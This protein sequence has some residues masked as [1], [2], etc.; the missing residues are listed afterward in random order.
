VIRAT[1]VLPLY[2]LALRLGHASALTSQLEAELRVVERDGAVVGADALASPPLAGLV[3]FREGG[4]LVAI[5]RGADVPRRV[6]GEGIGRRCERAPSSPA[7]NP[8]SQSIDFQP[9]P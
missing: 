7:R 8:A 5:A 6:V 3:E 4:E 2:F 1:A 9:N